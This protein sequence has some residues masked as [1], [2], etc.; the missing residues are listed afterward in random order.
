MAKKDVQEDKQNTKNGDGYILQ[1]EKQIKDLRA[2]HE[3]IR[4]LNNIEKFAATGRMARTIAHEVRNPLTNIGL[5]L[6]QLSGELPHND[7]V[8]LLLEMMN[9]N[10]T[11]INLIVTDLLNSTKFAQ[12]SFSHTSVTDVLREVIKQSSGLANQRHVSIEEQMGSKLPEVLIDVEKLKTAF[13]NIINYSIE[14]A[15]E[16]EGKIIV[17]ASSQN[18]KCFITIHNNGTDI[19]AEKTEQIFEPY[20]TSKNASGLALTHA[21]NVILNHG[22]NISFESEAGKGNTFTIVFEFA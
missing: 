4:R 9:R 12:L 2:S 14:S 15:S 13:E 8:S 6:E 22:G 20:S 18:S 17:S 19:N 16:H 1:L 3:E 10:T 11:R 21:Q 5:A 7:D